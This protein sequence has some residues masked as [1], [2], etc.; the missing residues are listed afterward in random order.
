MPT[1]QQLAVDSAKIWG[2][3]TKLVAD[4]SQLLFRYSG[5]AQLVQFMA[6][7]WASGNN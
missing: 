5:A 4:I 3:L 2:T 7:V 1:I 6:F